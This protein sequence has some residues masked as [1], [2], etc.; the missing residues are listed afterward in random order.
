MINYLKKLYRDVTNPASLIRL[1]IDTFILLVGL[2]LMFNIH[3]WFG[4]EPKWIQATIMLVVYFTTT[5][6]LNSKWK[7]KGNEE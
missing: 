6:L 5:W 1:L 2:F 3:D 4:A 7:R